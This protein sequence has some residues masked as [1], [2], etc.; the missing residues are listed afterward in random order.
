MHD[1]DYR[2]HLRNVSKKLDRAA[3]KIDHAAATLYACLATLEEHQ[4]L[5]DKDMLAL[6][7][8]ITRKASLRAQR[9]PVH[10]TETPAGQRPT[11]ELAHDLRSMADAF[12]ISATG[13]PVYAWRESLPMSIPRKLALERNSELLF[14]R[15]AVRWFHRY[16][17]KN[18]INATL[19]IDAEIVAS[20]VETALDIPPDDNQLTADAILA[21]AREIYDENR[22]QYRIPRIR[23]KQKKKRIPPSLLCRF[24]QEPS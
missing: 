22:G 10:E 1:S 18:R 14:R 12:R 16:I 19:H 13:K 20:V 4:M 9:P 7:A 5:L 11:T 2:E 23:L 6:V 3:D 15:E 17:H 24:P 8:R 21:E